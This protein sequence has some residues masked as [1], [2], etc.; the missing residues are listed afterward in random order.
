MTS[1]AASPK[2]IRWLNTP[3]RYGTAAILM[4]W[5]MVLL[6]VG[7]YVTM[8]F[9]HALPGSEASVEAWH[10]MF[11]L[12]V[13]VLAALRLAVRLVGPAPQIRP[14]PPAWQ[15]RVAKLT[16]AALY[17]FMIAMPVLGWLTLSGEGEIARVP[18]LGLP[19]PVLAGVGEPLGETTEELH[20]IVAV[21]GYW[22]IGL[23]TA[24]ALYHHYLVRD[25]TLRRM[26]PSRSRAQSRRPLS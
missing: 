10:Y 17:L 20:K 18:G 22:L 5:L 25:D 14:Q 4:H 9:E 6:L 24:A 12:S 15:R 26:L 2:S 13:L 7:S 8:E 11:G 1:V 3:E 21:A 16:H 23:H 19:I